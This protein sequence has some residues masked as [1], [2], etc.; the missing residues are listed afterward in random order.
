L[1]EADPLRPLVTLQFILSLAGR[2]AEADAEYA[3]TCEMEPDTPGLPHWFAF[4]QSMATK[5]PEDVKNDFAKLIATRSMPPVFGEELLARFDDPEA[6]VAWIEDKVTDASPAT[7]NVLI[8]FA[9]F[10]AYF[11]ARDL[12]LSLLR[13]Q[14]DQPGAG[15]PLLNIWHPVF[16][17][18]RTLDGF[19][20]FVRDLG[21]YDFWRE[22]GKWGDFARP[23][24]DDDFEIFR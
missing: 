3:R 11:G 15:S 7:R 16:T 12:A 4:A 22:T 5:N 18:V 6:A 21:I 13:R 17:E 19:K 8:L 14:F 9:F 23:K 20:A 10:A 1:R 2:Y 24:G